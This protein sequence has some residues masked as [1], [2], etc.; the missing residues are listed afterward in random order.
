MKRTF[1]SAEVLDFELNQYLY[2]LSSEEPANHNINCPLEYWLPA[3]PFF[4]I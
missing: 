3:K 4:H 2:N 1:A